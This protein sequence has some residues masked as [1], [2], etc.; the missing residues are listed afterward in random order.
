MAMSQ[1]TPDDWPANESISGPQQSVGVT[2]ATVGTASGFGDAVEAR[3]R[4]AS[5]FAMPAAHNEANKPGFS[6]LA[7]SALPA[8]ERHKK[9]SN[10]NDMR[11]DLQVE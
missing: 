11:A 8:P 3:D 7:F 4:A 10:Q 9:H 5:T 6:A 1:L 2:L